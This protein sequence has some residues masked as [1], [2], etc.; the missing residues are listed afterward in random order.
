M[1]Q[2]LTE[3]MLNHALERGQQLCYTPKGTLYNI[4]CIGKAKDDNTG[5]WEPSITYSDGENFYTRFIRNMRKFSIQSEDE[6]NLTEEPKF[7]TTVFAIHD[8]EAFRTFRGMISQMMVNYLHEKPPAFGVVA[9]SNDNEIL[10]LEM[11]EAL[12]E[13]HD[14][15]RHELQQLLTRRNL[16]YS[17]LENQQK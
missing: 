7:F 1:T 8:A 17:D 6:A 15:E 13:D 14:S 12:V 5:E 3:E 2:P 9:S 10:R 4:L 11:I 16:K